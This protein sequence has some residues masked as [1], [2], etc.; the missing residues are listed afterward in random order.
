[1]HELIDL[2]QSLTADQPERGGFVLS[3][4]LNW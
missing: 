3:S 4:I 2:F 1:M